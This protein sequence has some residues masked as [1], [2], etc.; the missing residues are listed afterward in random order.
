MLG[1]KIKNLREEQNM[2]QS[3]LAKLLNISPSTIGMWEQNRRSPDNESLKRIADFFGVSIDYLLDRVDYNNLLGAMLKDKRE[4][5][6]LSLR[7]AAQLIGISHSYLSIL[8]QGVDKRKNTPVKPT[9]EILKYISAAY[10]ID[11]TYL[12]NLV[13]YIANTEDDLSDKEILDIEK[14]AQR[15]IDNIDKLDTVEF[16][17]TPADDDDKEY[18]KLAYQKFL[19]DVRIYNKQKYTPKKYRS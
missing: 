8:E 18:L 5:L 17:G 13:G 12:M 10:E 1:D 7:D 14:E 15:M 6:H 4:E 2:T 9:P 16:C 11:Y 19:S 3:T